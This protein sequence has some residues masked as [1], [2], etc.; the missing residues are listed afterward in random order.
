MT[1][2]TKFKAEI[3]FHDP[4]DVAPAVVELAKF[5]FSYTPEPALIDPVGPTV[6]GWLTGVTEL[7][8]DALYGHL[9]DISARSAAT[10][11]SGGASSPT[12]RRSRTWRA[13]F[14]A[15]LR[16]GGTA[17]LVERRGLLKGGLSLGALTL[18]TGCDV[19]HTDQV[20][21][22]LNRM[23]QWNDRV[24]A[25]LFNPNRLI[26][27]YSEAEAVKDFRFNAY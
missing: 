16:E 3:L 12:N 1:N 27:T 24:Q 10:S 21:S 11:S 20:E 25:A 8:M 4:A 23:S 5:G 19:T 26:P 18:L 22:V 9:R 13:R 14:L 6:W 2:K 17:R 7:D 15:V